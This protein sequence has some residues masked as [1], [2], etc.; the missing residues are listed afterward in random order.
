MTNS[1]KWLLHES[2]IK[3]LKCVAGSGQLS[4]IVEEV[5]VLDN[6]N[7]LRWVKPKELVLTSG[8]LLLDNEELQKQIVYELH[9]AG[10]AGLAIK[11]KSYFEEFPRAMIDE[12]NKV[13]FPL[14]EIPFYYSLSDV[15]K[16]I[17]S[18]LFQENM[19]KKE[20]EQRLLEEIADVFFSKRGVME[21]VYLIAEHFRRT[22]I[23]LNEDFQCLYAAK[24]MSEKNICSRGD[25]IRRVSIT[26]EHHDIF[27]FADKSERKVYNLTIIGSD[28][29][30]SLLVVEN[31]QKLTINDENLLKRCAKILSLCFQQEKVKQWNRY[32]FDN[33]YIKKFFEY[34]KGLSV[35]DER[36]LEELLSEVRFPMDKK[37]VLLLVELDKEEGY[38]RNLTDL[39]KQVFAS[40]IKEKSSEKLIVDYGRTLFMYLFADKKKSSTYIEDKARKIAGQFIEKAGVMY[41]EY[42]VRVGIST[43]NSGREGVARSYREAEKALDI[44]EKMAVADPV[45]LFSQYAIYDY[46]IQ[47]PV[48]ERET[49]YGK[50]NVLDEY[51]RENNTE[52][53]NTLLSYLDHQCNATETA[54]ALYIHRNTFIKRLDKI[55]ELLYTDLETMEDVLALWTE[56]LAFRYFKD[57]RIKK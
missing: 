48:T 5:S 25:E 46:F 45:C 40:N 43:C 44:A 12:A 31:G 39:L 1:L 57:R 15:T 21:I 55:K 9:D 30:N 53:A 2:G 22:V 51:D 47:Y 24:R 29:K 38:E 37:R 32:N 3:N 52:Y 26:D 33:I 28:I 17:Y 20:R 18:H 41:P 23:L 11:S 14:L 16:I 54:K 13:G 10:C 36:E 27:R 7:T 8:Y 56:S 6:P 34:V 42:K 19:E 50:I 35:C 49:L 4:N